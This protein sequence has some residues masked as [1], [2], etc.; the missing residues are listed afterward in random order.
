MSR[1]KNLTYN[2][3]RIIQKGIQ[4]CASKRA[5]GKTIGSVNIIVNEI[6]IVHAMLHLYAKEKINLLEFVMGAAIIIHADLTK[7]EREN[8][9][10]IFSSSTN[11]FYIMRCFKRNLKGMTPTQFGNHANPNLL[12]LVI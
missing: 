1:N 6:L 5:I 12:P 10:S 2:G 4:E 3:R 8:I 11:N 9:A 7:E